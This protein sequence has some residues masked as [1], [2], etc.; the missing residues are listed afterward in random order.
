MNTE[1]VCVS[2][3]LSDSVICELGTGK[4]SLI[5]CF[6]NFNIPQVPFPTPMF[7]ITAALTNLD[8]AQKEF[9]VTARI[10][11]PANGMVLRSVGAHCELNEPLVLTKELVMEFPMPVMPFLIP[12]PGNYLIVILVNNVQAGKRLLTVNSINAPVNPP[13]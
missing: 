5:G 13:K 2:I 7:Y 11:D 3:M 1:P 6:N 12:K 4:N 8:P 10:E 9:D